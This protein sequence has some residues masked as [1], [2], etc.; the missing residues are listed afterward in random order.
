TPR[1]KTPSVARF[2]TTPV[3]RAF[4]LRATGLPAD[5]GPRTAVCKSRPEPRRRPP[6]PR[7]CGGWG[8]EGAVAITQQH[9][10]LR[11]DA[12]ETADAVDHQAVEAGA[13]ERPAASFVALASLP[14]L[15]D[16][17][18]ALQLLHHRQKRL[19]LQV[20]LED[21]TPVGRLS[22]VGESGSLLPPRA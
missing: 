11:D 8:P 10:E 20:E 6:R 14:A 7:G 4:E 21:G 1:G 2:F 19:V 16:P 3:P 18:S 12:I 22:Y 17:A 13:V 9:P 5:S 15:V